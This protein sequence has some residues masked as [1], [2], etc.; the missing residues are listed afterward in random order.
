MKNG[1]D[2]RKIQGGEYGAINFNN[3]I[4][5]PDSVLR[6]IDI[7]N[8]PDR[9]YR[10]LLQNQYRAIQAD[11]EEIIRIATRLRRLVMM[12]DEQLT[13]F[14]KRIKERCCNLKILEKVYTKFDTK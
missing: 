7:N 4:P 2:F 14:D 6:L 9:R 5:V 13:S 12:E 10:R 8:V 11:S 3:M 1:K